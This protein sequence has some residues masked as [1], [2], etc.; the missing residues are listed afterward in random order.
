[1]IDHENHLIIFITLC[2][3]HGIVLSKKKV[4][5]KKKEIEFLGMIIDSKDIKL[6]SHITEKI[7]D[8]PDELRTKEM[9]HKFLGC[10]NYSFDFIKDLPKERQELQKLLTK[11]NQIGWSEK[12]TIIVKR[13]K[14]ICLDLP[15]LRL[16][17]E[18][19]NLILQIDASDKY[20]AAILKTNLGEICRYTSGTF[21]KNQINYGINEK[22]LLAII[23]GINKFEIF[24]LPKPFIIE[25]YNT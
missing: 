14:N 21:N 23:K 12:H 16:P 5:I 8:F 24:V 11:K 2:K 15:K 13:L 7:K 3:E 1:M 25:T 10:L 6:Q 17:N 19:D 18:N 22:D 4:D 9:I 20:W